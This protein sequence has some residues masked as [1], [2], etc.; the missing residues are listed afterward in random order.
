MNGSQDMTVEVDVKIRAVPSS[1]IGSHFAS[2]DST[3]SPL[4]SRVHRATRATT[5]GA[6]TG[7]TPPADPGRSV[8]VRRDVW[9]IGESLSE[10]DWD[11]LRSVY[12]HR[13]LTVR[14]VY[15]LHFADLSLTHG[16]RSAQ[17]V[18]ER[19]RGLHVLGDIERRKGGSE[20]GS[21]GMVHFVD[22][23]G[24]RLLRAETGRPVRRHL[25]DPSETFLKH[26]LA[27]ADVHVTLACAHR[28]GELELLSYTMEPACWRRYIAPGG[29]RLTLKPDMHFSVSPS[30][31]SD[32]IDDYFLEVDRGTE[33]I[34]RL[35]KKCR[36]YETYRRTGIE[37]DRNDG[38]FPRIIWSMSAKDPAK[39][40]RRKVALRE[41]IDRDRNLPSELFCVIVADE[42][43]SLTKQGGSL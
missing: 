38:A 8:V 35:I 36:D 26:T 27:I 25:T 17:R 5:D 1:R 12:E 2:A 23:N 41:A 37:Q 14:Q 39:A 9:S 11:I 21:D 16:R 18:L 29:A 3:A 33:P 19:L 42:L 24:E 40:Q 31:G 43:V 20:A 28:T 4:V 30:V 15:E 7:T 13:F 34:P 10:R 32:Y 22:T 6:H